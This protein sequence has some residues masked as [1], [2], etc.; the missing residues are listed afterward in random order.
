[1]LRKLG[2]A[3]VPAAGELG[4]WGAAVSSGTGA[5]AGRRGEARHVGGS[6]RRLPFRE[7]ER[8]LQRQEVEICFPPEMNVASGGK[9]WE[10]SAATCCRPR[11]GLGHIS[12]R[13]LA[14]LSCNDTRCPRL[15]DQS[16]CHGIWSGS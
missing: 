1:M 8:G 7:L 5:F 3:G 13:L 9:G 12:K 6:A 2:K 15:F 11:T 10:S 14:L 4:R 16:T